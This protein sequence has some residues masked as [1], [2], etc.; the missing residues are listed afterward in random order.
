M[1][2]IVISLLFF[3]CGAAF[4]RGATQTWNLVDLYGMQASDAKPA[5]DTALADA[6]SY[7]SANPNDE[8]VLYFPAGTWNVVHSSSEGI[9]INNWS[10]GKLTL[11]GASSSQSSAQEE[12]SESAA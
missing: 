2:R 3:V 6:K 5:I 8:V 4:V 10:A 12:K 7:L 11:R 9:Y 1:K